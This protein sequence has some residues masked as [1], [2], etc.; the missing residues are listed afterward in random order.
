MKAR[1][2]SIQAKEQVFMTKWD[3]FCYHIVSQAQKRNDDKMKKFGTEVMKIPLKI[4]Q[5]FA[6]QF[7]KTCIQIHSVA[8]FQWR[9]LYMPSIRS[10]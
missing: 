6:R 9:I 2:D 3:R 4:K 8:F 5:L 1:L 7:I 10:S